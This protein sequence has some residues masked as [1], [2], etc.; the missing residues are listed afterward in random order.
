MDASMRWRLIAAAMLLLA[1]GA[2]VVTHF[3]PAGPFADAL[4]DAL[5]GLGLYHVALKDPKA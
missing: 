1:W 2:L 4:K 5:F 3:V